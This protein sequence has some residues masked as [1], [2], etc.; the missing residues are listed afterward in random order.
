MAHN[1][2]SN[3]TLVYHA[4]VITRFQT[5]ENEIIGITL[6]LSSFKHSGSILE[7]EQSDS[8]LGQVYY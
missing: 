6:L 5:S 7:P 8:K 1:F 2:Y 3:F 4:Q